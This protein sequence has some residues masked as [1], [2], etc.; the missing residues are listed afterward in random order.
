[1]FYYFH[2]AVISIK[3]QELAQ[4]FDTLTESV[5]TLTITIVK[6][7]IRPPLPSNFLF[8]V[9]LPTLIF[10]RLLKLFKTYGILKSFFRLFFK[11]FLY[12]FHTIF[13][14]KVCQPTHP[15]NILDVTRS[16][17]FSFGLI[18]IQ[19]NSDQSPRL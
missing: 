12:F 16:Q 5:F 7:Y 14:L 3:Y 4:F 9:T 13:F 6:S 8:P 17:N 19:S 1:M 2:T 11:G 15:E 18:C 10:W